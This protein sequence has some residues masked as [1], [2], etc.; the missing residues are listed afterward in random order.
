M[1]KLCSLLL[2]LL[3]VSCSSLSLATK[4]SHALYKFKSLTYADVKYQASRIYYRNV[5]QESIYW[6][7]AY[8]GSITAWETINR[9]QYRWDNFYGAG[10]GNFTWLGWFSPPHIDTWYSACKLAPTVVDPRKIISPR[11]GK[12]IE[13]S[14]TAGSTL[15]L[16]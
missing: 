6:M 12:L 1:K 16:D 5:T 14:S 13:I 15:S 7:P 10:A 3:L 11:T 4:S 9:Q 8:E 2:L